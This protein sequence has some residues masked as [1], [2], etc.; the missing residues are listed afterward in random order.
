MLTLEPESGI[1]Q[2]YLLTGI[3]K[4]STTVHIIFETLFSDCFLFPNITNDDKSD[5]SNEV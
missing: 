4:P 3:A 5:M 1:S 2:G